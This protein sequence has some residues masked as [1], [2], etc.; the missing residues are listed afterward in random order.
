M[1]EESSLVPPLGRKRCAHEVLSRNGKRGKKQC[2]QEATPDVVLCG[3]HLRQLGGDSG[4]KRFEEC[5]YCVLVTAELQ[6]HLPRCPAARHKREREALPYFRLDCNKLVL[7]AGN[8]EKT[9]DE[10]PLGE[11][12][13]E[14]LRRLGV[15]LPLENHCTEQ[16][17]DETEYQELLA[18]MQG[19]HKRHQPKHLRQSLSIARHLLRLI[20]QEPPKPIHGE[21]EGGT[22]EATAA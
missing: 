6:R 18:Y 20:V 10:R 16:L 12:I 3:L 22:V 13:E 17:G 14:G 5:P 19:V 21:K 9:R 11:A 7:S 8:E 4:G 2:H 15:G 1:T